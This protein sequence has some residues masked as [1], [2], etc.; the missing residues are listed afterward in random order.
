LCAS[1]SAKKIELEHPLVVVVAVG[2]VGV[3][4]HGFHNQ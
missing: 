2:A 4:F 1:S 3:L